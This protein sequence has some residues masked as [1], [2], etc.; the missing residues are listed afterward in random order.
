LFKHEIRAWLNSPAAYIVGGLFL[1]IAALYYTLDN[2][3]G[4]SGGLSELYSTLGTLFLFIVPVL[5]SRVI[6]E[7]RRN[8]MQTLLITSPSGIAGIVLGKFFALFALLA[9]LDREIT[10]YGLFDDGKTDA[11]YIEVKELLENYVKHSGGKVRIVYA[12]PDRDTRIIP[13]RGL[14]GFFEKTEYK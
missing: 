14:D 8:G 7:E 5:T 6:A 10:V 9:G 1:A 12:D 2:V 11:D 3:R 13:R 4:R